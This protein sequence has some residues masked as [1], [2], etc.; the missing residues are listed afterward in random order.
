[1]SNERKAMVDYATSQQLGILDSII[2]G[3]IGKAFSKLAD[4]LQ[5]WAGEINGFKTEFT[6][7]KAEWVPFNASFPS[8]FSL[9]ELIK[10][11]A[12][13]EYNEFGLLLKKKPDELKLAIERIDPI[14]ARFKSQYPPTKADEIDTKLRKIGPLEESVRRLTQSAQAMRTGANN[15]PQRQN[16]NFSNTG[17]FTETAE[18]INRLE[19]R[20]D[21]LIRAIDS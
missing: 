1:M 12:G 7:F 6:A 5:T 16:A 10:Q 8:L 19:D 11:R 4:D 21:S 9:E 17:S 14:V 13:L 20:I 3:E 15:A 18:Q 2:R